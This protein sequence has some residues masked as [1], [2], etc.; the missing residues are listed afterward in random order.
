MYCVRIDFLNG[1]LHVKQGA[2]GTIV[3]NG[4][5]NQ[6]YGGL[7]LTPLE[8][9]ESKLGVSPTTV[10]LRI[11]DTTT[12]TQV[13]SLD[14]TNFYGRFVYIFGN[15]ENG[16]QLSNP[17]YVTRIKSYTYFQ[18]GSMS[19]DVE[20]TIPDFWKKPLCQT[21]SSDE[22]T[23]IPAQ[24]SGKKIAL[25]AGTISKTQ[26][27]EYEEEG[28][29]AY[30]GLFPGYR[31][32][33]SGD[34]VFAMIRMPKIASSYAFSSVYSSIGNEQN[35]SLL[36]VSSVDFTQNGITGTTVYITY[37][38]GTV[39]WNYLT[40]YPS[41]PNAYS[42]L[43][44]V[45]RVLV[46]YGQ[47]DINMSSAASI[48]FLKRCKDREIDSLSGI[49]NLSF[50][51]QGDETVGDFV[52]RIC[53]DIGCKYRMVNGKVEL[54][55]EAFSS[56]P[57]IQLYGWQISNYVRLAE[58]GNIVNKQSEMWG[59]H[60][61]PVL[62][63]DHTYSSDDD[64]SQTKLDSQ[65]VY[66][67]FDSES[68]ENWFAYSPSQMYSLKKFLYWQL[69]DKQTATFSFNRSQ[70]QGVPLYPGNL[71]T[72][73]LC[74]DPSAGTKN[75]Y[76]RV[77]SFRENVE[78]GDLSIEATDETDLHEVDEG[79]SLLLIPGPKRSDVGL[80]NDSPK[81]NNPIVN[82][83]GV[84]Y[85][86]T[87]QRLIVDGDSYLKIDDW[88]DD[89][90]NLRAFD[91]WQFAMRVSRAASTANQFV[92]FAGSK[93]NTTSPWLGIR[94]VY[95]TNTLNFAISNGTTVTNFD[96]TG[97]WATAG[98]FYHIGID[99]L[100]LSGSSYQVGVY[101]SG[102]RVAN[103]TITIDF[104]ITGRFAIGCR[105]DGSQTTG[106]MTSGGKFHDVLMASNSNVLQVSDDFLT[107]YNQVRYH[108]S[109]FGG[110]EGFPKYD[111]SLPED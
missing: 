10:T 109:I 96:A 32:N 95:A 43:E 68:I 15:A 106:F 7:Q 77:N 56:E 16:I 61:N 67:V 47:G 100:K 75:R 45:R 102:Q 27:P 48:D 93:A 25:V 20:D 24:N 72:F 5:E 105:C 14:T 103:G 1:S 54:Y 88:S 89:V 6:F 53:Q 94:Y 82:T 52:S 104:D 98:T 83:G 87:Y 3:M 51:I 81:Y 36:T 91:R 42:T 84:A 110:Y 55:F 12:V 66:G 18:D 11:V 39:S 40:A 107:C 59:H 85:D 41:F 97:Q 4:T 58:Q 35:L 28:A 17:L 44:M 46:F 33:S 9:S 30:V 80:F 29:V 64:M 99:V 62:E 23:G 19:F 78:T 111:Y 26:I 69:I 8:M 63:E 2:A 50:I 49:S 60:I 70:L 57:S 92:M 65:Y 76:Y 90:F 74:C 73:S 31:T 86:G 22:F 101:K 79:I 38:P 108:P 21:L 34:S 13:R 71:L 37:E